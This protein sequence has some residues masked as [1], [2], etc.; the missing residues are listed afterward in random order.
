MKKKHTQ[1]SNLSLC[2]LI[3]SDHCIYID[4]R[5]LFL[6]HSLDVKLP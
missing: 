4:I 6:L 5:P 3:S 2:T 1:K